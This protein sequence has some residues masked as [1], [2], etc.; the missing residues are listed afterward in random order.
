[1]QKILVGAGECGLFAYQYFGDSQIY[2]FA[3]NHKT[4]QFMGKPVISLDQLK[5]LSASYDVIVSVQGQNRS[6]IK[7]QLAG[8]GIQ[9][10]KETF[11][12]RLK[13]YEENWHYEGAFTDEF[14]KRIPFANLY[15]DIGAEFGYYSKL[16]ADAMSPDSKLYLFEPEERKNKHLHR[17]FS[18]DKRITISNSAVSNKKGKIELFGLTDAATENV[19]FSFSADQN[20]SLK[21]VHDEKLRNDRKVVSFIA[22]TVKLD[23]IFTREIPD[24]V[25]MDI[26]GAEVFALEGMEHMIEQNQTVFFLEIHR[27]YIESIC[28]GGTNRMNDLFKRNKYHIYKCCRENECFEGQPKCVMAVEDLVNG[29]YLISPTAV[30]GLHHES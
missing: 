8:M 11:A 22:N 26:E 1:M 20:L 3:D 27:S 18:D 17:L 6:E 4:G 16:A 10:V 15:V 9:A 5:E 25:K 12:A 19:L 13:E 7:K 28:N 23:D 21:R 30:S 14:L 24:I 2:C 29:N